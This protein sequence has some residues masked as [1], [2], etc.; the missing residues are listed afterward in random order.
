MSFIFLVKISVNNLKVK[1]KVQRR[2]APQKTE[3]RVSSIC[4]VERLY[5]KFV[6][7]EG[8]PSTDPD[9]FYKNESGEF[10]RDADT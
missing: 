4:Q 10:T 1:W 9:T 7:T 6:K 5:P 8:S 3:L 2:K